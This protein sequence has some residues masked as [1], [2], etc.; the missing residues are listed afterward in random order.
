MEVVGAALDGARHRRERLVAM[1]GM[2]LSTPAT[3]DT[4]RAGLKRNLKTDVN[5]SSASTAASSTA[6][7]DV[8][9]VTPD[10]KHVRVSTAPTPKELFASPGDQGGEGLGRQNPENNIT[11]TCLNH[12]CGSMNNLVVIFQLKKYPTSLTSLR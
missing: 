11:Y 10:P 3:P 12:K 1:Q 2:A 5:P 7:G 4:G 6:K 8:E 9:K